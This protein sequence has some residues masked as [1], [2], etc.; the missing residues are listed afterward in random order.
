MSDIQE[1]ARL[2][3]DAA[4]AHVSAHGG[5]AFA[6][7]PVFAD[8]GDETAEG[9]RI[10]ILMPDD[11]GI[12]LRFVAGPFF[13]AAFAA[14]EVI[15]AADAPPSVRALRFL[16]TRC[17]EEWLTDQV[18]VLINRLVNASGIAA[19]QMPDYLQAPKHG[20]GPEAVFPIS[21]LGRLH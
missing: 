11:G 2:D 1:D 7:T 4:V 15:D 19:P 16:P 8:D 18:Q 3:F 10:F 9:A 13:S 17:D 21:F 5:A 14:N 12:G 6:V 20:A